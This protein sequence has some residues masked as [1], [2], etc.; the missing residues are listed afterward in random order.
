MKTAS[1]TLFDELYRKLNQEQKQAVDAIEGPVMV[2]AGPGTGKTHMLT[3]RIANIL[4]RTDTAPENILALTFTESAVYAMRKRLVELIGS[5]GYRVRMY[6]FHSFC[7]EIIRLY[8]DCFERIIGSSHIGEVEQVQL[9]E[10]IL[11]RARLRTL[12]PYG[13]PFY[14]L[15][16]ILTSIRE[17]KR[18]SYSPASFRAFIEK[19]LRELKGRDDLYHSTGPFKGRMRGKYAHALAKLEKSRELITLYARYE[20]ML[21]ARRLYDYEDMIVEV[22]RALH[23]N[24]DL[25]LSLQEQYQY[26]LADEHQ[27]ANNT[28]NALLE[29]LA[30]FHEHPNL[31]IVG[32]DKQAIFRFQG[33]SVENF[34]S[35]ANRYPDALIIHLSHNYRST[36][37]IL[38]AAH[39]L[40]SAGVNGSSTHA[41]LYA[42]GKKRGEKI[43]V[44]TIPS[45][46]DE[47]FFIANAIEEKVRVGMDPASIAVLYRD[48]ND[49]FDIA[50][51][52]AEKN[53]AYVIRS[54]RDTLAD[55]D[56]T[57]LIRLLHLIH[58]GGDRSSLSEALFIDFLGIEPF[59]AYSILAASADTKVPLIALLRDGKAL[60]K[61]GVRNPE[62]VLVFGRNL[63]SWT[64]HARNKL[65][66]DFFESIIAESGFL[67]HIMNLPAPQEKLSALA[68]LFEE[69]KRLSAAN[70]SYYLADF[71]RHIDTL[72]THKMRLS[73]KGSDVFEKGV[74]LLTAHRAKGLEFEHVYVTQAVSGHW[75]NRRSVQHFMLPGGLYTSEDSGDSDE[76]R[77]FYVALTRARTEV[78]ITVPLTGHERRP[79]LPSAFVEDIG[80]DLVRTSTVTLTKPLFR[81]TAVHVDSLE[82]PAAFTAGKDYLRRRF[83]DQGLSV[84]ALNNYLECPWK[85]FF[86]NLVRVP[87]LPTRQQFYGIAVHQTLKRFFDAMR[88]EQ[89]MSKKSVLALF[90][91]ELARVPLSEADA[92]EALVKGKKALGGYYDQYRKAFVVPVAT[93]LSVTGVFIDVPLSETHTER[94]LLRGIL[95]KVEPLSFDAASAGPLSVNVVDYKTSQPKSRGVLL[96]STKSASGNEKRQLVFYKLLLDRADR[97]LYEMF[98][99][100][101]DFVEPDRRGRYRK[102]RFEI[103]NA[104][105]AELE[106]CVRE[107][108]SHIMTFAF[109]DTRCSD[110]AC[111]H[112]ALRNMMKG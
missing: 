55:I 96:G 8:P 76:R 65:L 27:D 49:A 106:T 94:V 81:N 82:A 72:S 36:Q 66:A 90:E 22:V 99:G 62:P 15:H 109:W 7:N 78:S 68:V 38:D 97:S 61:A 69:V 13:N 58:D 33:A 51:A 50:H 20:N 93:E 92:R 43:A 41:P 3:L 45:Q 79:L 85:Y 71:I 64:T 73:G 88:E 110:K 101:I 23:S 32:D 29:L 42:H 112:C 83:L 84:T 102:E 54:D 28:Q 37:S 46:A 26:I 14:Y 80:T 59:D 77:L 75:G 44:H 10:E 86:T 57:K 30:S 35:F 63:S 89:V 107:V 34:R 25:L 56:I 67:A 24:A 39:K 5:R 103:T 53:I 40:I 19:E 9:M 70:P 21:R 31:F 48:N 18:E 87:R 108:A 12:K 4:R 104:D 2:I 11:T 98:S 16:A 1:K 100:E 6:T 105:V 95:D 17:L 91:R 74:E 47:A 60:E 111:E 52:L